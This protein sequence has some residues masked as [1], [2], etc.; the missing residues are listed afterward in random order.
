[1]QPRPLWLPDTGHT[2]GR[3]EEILQCVEAEKQVALKAVLAHDPRPSYQND[4][5]RVYGMEFAG[6]EVKFRVEDGVLYV[7]QV[8]TVD[9]V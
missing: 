2:L 3:P 1:M 5:T 8:E 6:Y 7:T 4:P 9:K